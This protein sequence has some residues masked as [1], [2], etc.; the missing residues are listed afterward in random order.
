[1][2]N[3]SSVVP[4]EGPS[5][6]ASITSVVSQ[7][8][9]R[10][11]S[12]ASSSQQARPPKRRSNQEDV[13]DKYVLGEML[14]S[15]SFGQV[16]EV[17]LKNFPDKVRACKVIER[18]AEDEPED[19]WS[20]SALFRR[21]V[22]LLQTM[23][24]RNIVRFWDFHADKHF[25]Y[26]VMDLCRGGEIFDMVLALKRFTEADAAILGAQMLAAIDYI[27]KMSIMHRDIK[28]ENF[29]L[30]EKSPTATVK[31]IDF[32][33]AVKFS[34]GEEFNE[35]CGSPH[36]LA[37]ELIGQRYGHLVDIWAFGVMIYL[38]M[39]GHYPFDAD[40]TK[41]IMVKVIAGTIR[42]VTKVRLSDKTVRF[43][44]RVLQPKA[45]KRVS[46]EVALEDEWITSAGSPD[47]ELERELSE[48]NLT[49][50][51]RS[52]ARK[53][54]SNRREVDPQVEKSR[55]AKLQ[56]IGKDFEKGIRHGERLGDTPNEEFMSKPEFVRRKNR[57][58]TAPGL[59]IRETVKTYAAAAQAKMQALRKGNGSI[60][61]GSSSSSKAKFSS[62]MSAT[63]QQDEQSQGR[64]CTP[65]FG[66]AGGF[67]VFTGSNPAQKSAAQSESVAQA[68]S[69]KGGLMYIGK[70]HPEEI[71][72]FKKT[73]EDWRE[74]QAERETDENGRSIS[75]S[76]EM[77]PH[78]KRVS[79]EECVLSVEAEMKRAVAQRNKESLIE[80]MP[81]IPSMRKEEV[82]V[83]IGDLPLLPVALPPRNRVESEGPT[84]SIGST[85]SKHAERI[86]TD[87]LS[88]EGVVFNT[89]REQRGADNT[90]REQ[91]G[92]TSRLRDGIP[93]AGSPVTQSAGASGRSSGRKT[94]TGGKK[95]PRPK[96]ESLIQVMSSK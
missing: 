86:S 69:M 43:L 38:M 79:T 36:Y 1:M 33:M 50:V 5:P 72:I 18:E 96:A 44:K 13:R 42:W 25:L 31:M 19:E 51:V 66:D 46:A 65:F 14:G 62:V 82:E 7:Q 61:G 16:I 55:T 10:Q 49:E 30:A 54:T 22:A 21:E 40:H 2:G 57:L 95:P 75:G 12:K 68:K 37:P 28:A 81:S 93:E 87:G 47:A 20:V 39:Y 48:A 64:A 58:V 78:T 34:P 52:A 76:V 17:K 35:L 74:Q 32:G 70:L 90:E 84:T 4:N 73:W 11:S 24:H 77:R 88:A 80:P 56:E 59:Q 6:S 45:K 8:A 9:G 71:E 89:E 26:V 83:S 60:T 41:A 67:G 23:K 85:S 53:L 29:L 3:S 15:G 63:P 92:I 27:H 94:S 91:R